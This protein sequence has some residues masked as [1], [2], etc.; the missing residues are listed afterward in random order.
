MEYHFTS[1]SSVDSKK[2]SDPIIGL[3]LPSCLSICLFWLLPCKLVFLSC[4]TIL[5]CLFK[6]RSEVLRKRLGSCDPWMSLVDRQ[7][8]FRIT[9]L[10]H[11]VGALL[12]SFLSKVV[13]YSRE[14]IPI[15][16]ALRSEQRSKTWEFIGL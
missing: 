9:W 11:L 12:M 13:R 6:C 10:G 1:S 7:L 14:N 5:G 3:I 2:F 4:L 8:Q 16:G 15:S